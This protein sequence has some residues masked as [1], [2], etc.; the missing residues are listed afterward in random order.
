MSHDRRNI[1]CR[2]ASRKP[3][4]DR[5]WQE[6]SVFRSGIRGHMAAKFTNLYRIAWLPRL[7]LAGR[8][9]FPPFPA[10]PLQ[11]GTRPEG[12]KRILFLGDISAVANRRQPEISDGMKAIFASTDIVIAN[13]ETPV[14]ARS[15][16]PFLTGIGMS[17]AMHP[18]FLAGLLS[19]WGVAPDRL[20]LSLAN[21]H[22]GD[23]GRAGI[24]ETIATLEKMRI[25]AVGRE[26]G[27]QVF[28]MAGLRLALLSFTEW[29]NG[30]AKVLRAAVNCETPT[31]AE[32]VSPA[33]DL[34][35]MLPHWGTEFRFRPDERQRG[36]A[37]GYAQAGC[38]LVIGTHP[39]AI[40]PL[41]TIGK[42]LVAYSLGDCLGTPFM[43]T[44][45]PL[46]LSLALACDVMPGARVVGHEAHVYFRE[47][48][49]GYERL[50]LIGELPAGLR[51][52]VA[53]LAGRVME[54]FQN[55]N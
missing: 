25:R 30:D 39:H 7:L 24:A 16:T 13:L 42:T 45:W 38:D 50:S 43:R 47:A 9:H 19:N 46:R 29:I 12:A 28:E 15:S 32:A 10:A 54:P 35:V 44:P 37:R 33:A 26:R 23:Q 22:A 40:Q 2:R 20:I 11:A 6:R 34:A 27:W 31:R 52:K 8:Q 3:D 18:D 17:H 1:G 21:N 49:S 4:I 41:E 36:M 51:G 55:S 5:I 53:G 48:R 14:V